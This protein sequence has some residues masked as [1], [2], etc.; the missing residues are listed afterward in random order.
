MLQPYIESAT[1]LSDMYVFNC[2]CE[3][4]TKKLYAKMLRG[5]YVVQAC[6]CL[7]ISFGSLKR[8]ADYN[9]CLEFLILPLS[10]RLKSTCDTRTIHFYYK[11]SSFSL[12][13]KKNG[14][15]KQR[16]LRN[17]KLKVNRASMTEEQRRERLRIR[18]EKDRARRI[19]K[20]LQEEKKK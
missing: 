19:T 17:E 18:C 5:N 9:F 7:K 20:K 8:S 15:N 4:N 12:V 10:G 11:L 1:A 16:S 2:L 6:A 3:N 14:K 13:R